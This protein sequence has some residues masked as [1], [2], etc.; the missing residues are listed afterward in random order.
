MGMVEK[1]TAI[2]KKEKLNLLRDTPTHR[3]TQNVDKDS[4]TNLTSE[5]AYTDC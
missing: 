1:Y 2:Q 3:E 5:C 4:S